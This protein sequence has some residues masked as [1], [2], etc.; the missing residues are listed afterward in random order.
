MVESTSGIALHYYKYSETSVLA[1]IFT[2]NLGLQSYAIRGVRTKRS[3]NKL[4]LLFP[5]NILEM[6]VT[7]NPK[8]DVQY[9][10]EMRAGISLYKIYNDIHKK[11]LC[12]FISEI[13][14]RILVENKK[15]EKIYN[16][17]EKIILNI[18]SS[19]NLDKNYAIL[20]LLKLSDFLGFLPNMSLIE[21]HDFKHLLAGHNMSE[22][23]INY[24]YL[25]LQNQLIDIPPINRKEI[26]NFMQNYYSSHYYNIKNLKTYKII[27]SLKA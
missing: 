8:K 2:K 16:F 5:L 4:N 13:L 11:L 18:N 17:I 23:N 10:K 14:I 25:L 1:K 3:K 6:E 9:I 12:S 22:K 26:F 24:I 15:E 20:F 27:E 19:D 7:N 21:D